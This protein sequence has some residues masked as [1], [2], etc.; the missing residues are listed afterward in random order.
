MMPLRHERPSREYMRELRAVARGAEALRNHLPKINLL[1]DGFPLAQ[2]EDFCAALVGLPNGTAEGSIAP[3]RA[4]D[5]ELNRI[6]QRFIPAHDG[7]DDDSP[8]PLVERDGDL[9]LR[10]GALLLAVRSAIERY[11]VESGE[12]LETD[13]SADRPS[14]PAAAAAGTSAIEAI[15]EAQ[16]QIASADGLCE[17]LDDEALA[18]IETEYRLVADAGTQLGVTKAS[19][20]TESPRV[21]VLGW[22]HDGMEG[23]ARELE[24]RLA[25]PRLAK[26]SKEIG[27]GL[28]E[29]LEAWAPVV[30]TVRVVVT[31]VGNIIV[32][33]RG[34]QSGEDD[35][36]PFDYIEVY[37]RLLRGERVPDA[38]APQVT[39][40]DLWQLRHDDDCH[41]LSIEERQRIVGD[42]K[43]F[44]DARLF[45][46]LTA[47]GRLYLSSTQVADIAPLRGLTALERLHIDRTQ[48]ADIEP[49]R[50]LTNLESLWIQGT[51][52]QDTSALD[53]LK[54]KLTIYGP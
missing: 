2:V 15:D 53:H 8:A 31:R 4:A 47:L 46:N 35:P 48:V 41:H 43:D 26:I 14:N 20:E 50:G 49:L 40:I 25:D 38:W 37:N 11:K 44:S 42:P 12:E 3:L 51:P 24:K 27:D 13:V 45:A 52:V 34:D 7:E 18:A 17:A 1:P 10:L 36:G 33:L 5:S 32:I 6:R 19:L 30:T 21:T 22:L 9:D 16:D 28:R 54:P 29:I 39:E 23:S